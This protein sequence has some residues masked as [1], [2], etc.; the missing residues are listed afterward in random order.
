MLESWSVTRKQIVLSPLVVRASVCFQLVCFDHYNAFYEN[1]VCD[2][3]SS[4]KI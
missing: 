1:L 2:N 3:V 4:D